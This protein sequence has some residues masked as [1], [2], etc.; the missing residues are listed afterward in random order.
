LFDPHVL[1]HLFFFLLLPETFRL[2][3]VRRWM[4]FYWPSGSIHQ[5]PF[6]FFYSLHWRFCF[7][8]LPVR[9]DAWFLFIFFRKALTDPCVFRRCLPPPFWHAS[10]TV[11][12][13]DGLIRFGSFPFVQL[14]GLVSFCSVL[15]HFPIFFVS[16]AVPSFL[17]FPAPDLFFRSSMSFPPLPFSP[18]AFV[19]PG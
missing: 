9:F 5:D 15:Y 6:F 1:F 2:C 17:L 11:S 7:F 13:R 14:S 8:S 10:L 12:S 19:F 16:G 18:S 3:H 4:L